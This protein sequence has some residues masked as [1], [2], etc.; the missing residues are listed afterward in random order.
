MLFS[1]NKND[2]QARILPLFVVHGGLTNFAGLLLVQA[3]LSQSLYYV[4]FSCDPV[5]GMPVTEG[6]N[7]SDGNKNRCHDMPGQYIITPDA[8]E[9]IF[10]MP[11]VT[12]PLGD[13]CPLRI[14]RWTF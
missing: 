11:M 6:Q 9:G 10:R 12:V 2:A 14:V 5:L 3:H 8:C 4:T 1:Q 7:A 13:G